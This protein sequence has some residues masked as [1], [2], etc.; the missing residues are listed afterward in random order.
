MHNIIKQYAFVH[1]GPKNITHG[2]PQ[3]SADPILI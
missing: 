3:P 2:M 1:M